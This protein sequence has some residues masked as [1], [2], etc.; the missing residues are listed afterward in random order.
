MKS[1]TTSLHNYL[2][3][4]PDIF[5][6]E[7]KEPGYFVKELTWSQGQDW[8][9]G[10]F[11]GAGDARIRGESSTHYTKLPTYQGV[12]ERIHAFSPDARLIYQLRD[13]VERS[14]SH[15]WHNVRDVHYVGERRG[16]MEALRDD[17]QYLGYSDYAAQLE[18]YFRLFGRERVYILTFEQMT[19]APLAEIQK[20]FAWLG[21]DAGFVPQ[22]LDERWNV[23]PEQAQQVRG[24]GLLNRLRYSRAWG[25]VSP[26]VPKS[27]KGVGNR[28]A[29]RP[30]GKG[31]HDKAAAIA[32]LRPLLQQKTA[33]LC[34]LL[35][36]QFPEWKTLYGGG[37]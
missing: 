4:H 12:A 6:C 10:L 3:M 33:A 26:L 31:D 24:L 7:P 11:A 18:P 32:Y 22:G 16:L 13:P 21:V 19:T 30:V 36:R 14:I 15:Y 20:I 27:L 23:A 17:P 8:Y 2:N 28:L 5:M 37:R 35:G 29:A 34:T 1:G 25:A 9:L